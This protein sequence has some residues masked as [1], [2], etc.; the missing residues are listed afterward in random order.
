GATGATGPQGPAGPAGATGAAGQGVPTGGTAGQVLTKINGTDYNTQ[1]TT[2]S[3][4]GAS[5]HYTESLAESSTTSTSNQTKAT[6]TL[7][8]AGTYIVA[9]GGQVKTSTNLKYVYYQ[10]A[11]SGTPP[12]ST[13]STA[14]NQSTATAYTSFSSVN[15]IRVTASTN[16]AVTYRTEGGG[17]TAYI[18]NVTISAIK[19]SP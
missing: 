12:F 6:L 7:P 17:A 9:I 14:T 1:W 16:I 2:P 5:T 18:Q 8:S 19:V 4:G 15:L 13:I 3:S 10:F 11:V